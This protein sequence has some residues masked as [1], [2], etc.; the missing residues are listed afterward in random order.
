MD[1]KLISM[2]TLTVLIAATIGYFLSSVVFKQPVPHVKDKDYEIRQLGGRYTLIFSGYV[3][4]PRTSDIY[5]VI[6]CI[7]WRELGGEKHV[8][9]THIGD[10]QGESSL[11]FRVV[12]ECEYMVTIKSYTTEVLFSETPG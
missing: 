11:P 5:D 3:V 6:V 2:T 10:M 4:N 8:D 12:Y 7:R 9:S 1:R